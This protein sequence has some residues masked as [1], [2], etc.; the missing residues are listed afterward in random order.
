MMYNF[1]V[2]MNSKK[3]YQAVKC[4]PPAALRWLNRVMQDHEGA[5]Q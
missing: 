3:L 5:R 4:G 1:G 2:K